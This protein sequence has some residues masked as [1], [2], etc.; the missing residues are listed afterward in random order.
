M[1]LLSGSRIWLAP[2]FPL[3]LSDVA[4]LTSVEDE[5]SLGVNWAVQI[6]FA[7]GIVTVTPAFLAPMLLSHFQPLKVWFAGGVIVVPAASVGVAPVFKPVSVVGTVPD[8]VPALYDN[9]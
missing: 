7:A 1:S 3:E 9:W 2:R 6:T 8:P 4:S 5:D